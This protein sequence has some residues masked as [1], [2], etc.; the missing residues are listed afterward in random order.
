M[1]E[2]KI[3]HLDH[4]ASEREAKKAFRHDQSWVVYPPGSHSVRYLTVVCNL[5]KRF[6]L[7]A[8]LEADEVRKRL[9]AGLSKQAFERLKSVLGVSNEELASASSIPLR[10]LLRR[11]IFKPEESDRILRIAVVF[12]HAIEVFGDIAKARQWFLKPREYFG[13]NTPLQFC[14]T[15]PGAEQVDE[16]LGRIE[17]GVFS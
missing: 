4:L 12:H 5:E 8:N 13:M 2:L 7:K 10:T 14:D 17:H 11:K 9:L 15:T 3:R 6:S 1:A 16:L